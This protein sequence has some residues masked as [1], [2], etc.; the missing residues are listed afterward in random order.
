MIPFPP[1]PPYTADE[2]WSAHFH[3]AYDRLLDLH[4]RSTRLLDLDDP[5]DPL[6]VRI[7]A[8]EIDDNAELLDHMEDQGIPADWVMEAALCLG[9]TKIGLLT[10]S[11]DGSWN[12]E[13]NECV[14][15]LLFVNYLCY[16]A[17]ATQTIWS[18]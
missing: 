11:N 3:A 13:E 10:L 18:R 6:R 9:L 5:G 17:P 8:D 12:E 2:P 4:R 16:T 15:L 7:L 1:I 14:R